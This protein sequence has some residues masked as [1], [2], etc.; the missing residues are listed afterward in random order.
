MRPAPKRLLLRYAGAIVLVAS[1][2]VATDRTA[3][4]ADTTN[5]AMPSTQA[6]SASQ[7][8]VIF[9]HGW[10]GDSSVFKAT[11]LVFQQQTNNQINPYYFDYARRSTTWAGA[12]VVA[13][14]LATYIDTVSKA[15]RSAG[16]NGKVLVVAH[17]MGGLATLYASARPGVGSDLG[18]VITFDT[19]Y[20]GSPLGNNVAAAWQ[21]VVTTVQDLKGVG[22]IAPQAGSDAQI[23]LGPHANGAPLPARCSS[24][25]LPPFLPASAPITEIAGSITV[26]RTFLGVHLYDIPLASDG[27]V[28]VT[29]SHGYLDARTQSQWPMGEKIRST[30]DECTVGSDTVLTAAEAAGWTKSLLAGFTAGAA[31]LF[32]DNNALDGLLSGHLTPGLAVYLV[33]MTVFAGCSHIKVYDDPTAQDQAIQAIRSDLAS[34]NP[35]TEQELLSAP[36]PALR[37]EPSGQLVKGQLPNAGNGAVG[38]DSSGGAAPAFG[39]ITGDGIGDAAAVISATSGAGGSDEYVELYTNG[40]NLTRLSEF[41]PVAAANVVDGHAFVLAMVIRNG[42]VLVDWETAQTGLGVFQFWS[43]RLH[44]NGHSIEIHDLAS[45]T[46]ITGMQLWSDPL[47]T[48]TSNSLGRVKVGMTQAQAETAAGFSF[49]VGGDGYVYPDVG[50]TRG[51]HLYVSAGPDAR[52]R[53][54]GA[55]GGVGVQ[56]VR[57]PEGVKIGD[58]ASKVTAVYGARATYVP[59]PPDGGL[60]PQDGYVVQEHGSALV[61]MLND[62]TQTIAGIADGPSD[63]T[64][65]SCTG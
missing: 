56:T 37:G 26:R 29:S 62:Q 35:V 58:P 59:I 5:C 6:Q 7:R 41:D 61:F 60:S 10:T 4:G 40:G 33:A 38:L 50:P 19:P 13:G 53:C 65:S 55:E 18:G 22:L 54:V 57:T 31:Q 64:P 16:G 52:V 12:D 30:T 21:N 2:L 47:L 11:G 1:L 45:H 9:V 27:V 32:A 63:L 15:Y 8:P 46:G 28:P 17:S 3:A 23:C 20:T 14:C 24:Q 42:D 39:D 43:A 44:W 49:G 25:D 34:L 48:I 51:A 36:V